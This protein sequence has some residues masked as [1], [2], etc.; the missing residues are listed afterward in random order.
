MQQVEKMQQ[1]DNILHY[2][3]I[4]NEY[5]NSEQFRKQHE[6]YIMDGWVDG[7]S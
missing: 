1:E 4:C 6:W 5:L 3:Y 2:G 7:L